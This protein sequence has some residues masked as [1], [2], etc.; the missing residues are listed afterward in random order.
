MSWPERPRGA[1]RLALLAAVAALGGCSVLSPAPTWELIKA[2]S[3]VAGMAL[4][5]GP[6]SAS[7]TVHHGDAVPARVCIEFNRD[8]QA[9]ELVPALLAELREHRVA[10]RVYEPGQ[11]L[12]DCAVWLRYVASIQWGTPPL[13]SDYRAYLAAASL[14]LHRADGRL[15]ASSSYLL[16]EGWGA[17]LGMGRWSSTRSKLAPVVKALLTGFES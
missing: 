1:A 4:A 2:G 13:S 9:T 16:D 11:G 7:Q 10:G 8:V 14:S 6:S 5:Y 12:P 17:P 15:L 3:G